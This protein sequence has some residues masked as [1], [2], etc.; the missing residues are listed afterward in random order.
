MSCPLT[1]ASD[2][3]LV[4]L[5]AVPEQPMGRGRACRFAVIDQHDGALAAVLLVGHARDVVCRA[6]ASHVLP[7]P[8]LS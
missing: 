8:P 3:E 6:A 4:R 2:A 1:D 5:V 7:S